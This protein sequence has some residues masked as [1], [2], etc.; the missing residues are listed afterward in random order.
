MTA[1][2]VG[3]ATDV[4][5][6]GQRQFRVSIVGATLLPWVVV[7]AAHHTGQVDTVPVATLGVVFG[8]AHVALT[9]LFYGDPEF[10]PV[11]TADRRR[12]LLAPPAAVAAGVAVFTLGPRPLQVAVLFAVQ[13]W[14][15]HHFTRQN[16]GVFSLYARARGGASLSAEERRVFDLTG[17]AGM[18]GTVQVA[19]AGFE[20]P[21]AGVFTTAGLAFLAAAVVLVVRLRPM[22]SWRLAGLAIAIGFY[23]PLFLYRPTLLVAVGAYGFAHGAQYVAMMIHLRGGRRSPWLWV[24]AVAAMLVLVGFPLRWAGQQP[25]GLVFGLY[26]GLVVSHFVIDAGAWKMREAGPRRYVTGRLPWLARQPTCTT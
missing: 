7:I 6:G 3:A 15:I 11:L 4:G 24:L 20:V 21:G 17:Y 22:P 12:F 16:L 5:P 23:L 9:G 1:I 14:Q 25:Y 2:A 13:V 19:V 18:C 8:A 26:T 10:R